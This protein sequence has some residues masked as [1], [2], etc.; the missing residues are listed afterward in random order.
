MKDMCNTHATYTCSLFLPQIDYIGGI[1]STVSHAMNTIGYMMCDVLC[2]ILC[3]LYESVSLRGV[4]LMSEDA[5]CYAT[6]YPTRL[7]ITWLWE[8]QEE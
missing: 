1:G 7:H 8:E 2:M 3:S 5:M 6:H 4:G